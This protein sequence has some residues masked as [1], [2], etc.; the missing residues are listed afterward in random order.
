[1]EGI[2]CLRHFESSPHCRDCAQQGDGLLLQR[3][4]K[5][6]YVSSSSR[7]LL[8]FITKKQSDRD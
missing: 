3:G 5:I 4:H 6:V 8:T 7:T 2:R 1:M